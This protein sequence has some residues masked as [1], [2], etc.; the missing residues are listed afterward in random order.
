MKTSELV[1]LLLALALTPFHLAA[2]SLAIGTNSVPILFE[3]PAIAMTN[4]NIIANESDVAERDGVVA[5]GCE[6]RADD[7]EAFFG[8][9]V[10]DVK[11]T[12]RICALNLGQCHTGYKR[13]S[14]NN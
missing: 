3:D 7:I 4:R 1:T 6:C 2:Q 11:V 9:L 5:Y 10:L 14:T 13:A 8:V 12:D